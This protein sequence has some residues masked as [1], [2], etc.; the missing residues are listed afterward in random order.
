[1]IPNYAKPIK[2]TLTVKAPPK[3]EDMIE[4]FKELAQEIEDATDFMMKEIENAVKTKAP[5]KDEKIQGKSVQKNQPVT[6]R[7]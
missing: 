7:R 4:G 2:R 1:M 5:A 3:K 6:P